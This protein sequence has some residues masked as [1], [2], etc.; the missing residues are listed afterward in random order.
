MFDENSRKCQLPNHDIIRTWVIKCNIN[1]CL[2]GAKYIMKY[3]L[4]WNE[5]VSNGMNVS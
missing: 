4:D 1:N 2:L 5:Q 3:E